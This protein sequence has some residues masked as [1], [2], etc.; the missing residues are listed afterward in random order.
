MGQNMRCFRCEATVSD[1]IHSV[2][3]K[4]SIHPSLHREPRILLVCSPQPNPGEWRGEDTCSVTGPNLKPIRVTACRSQGGDTNPS[5]RAK[6]SKE[7]NFRQTFPGF[8]SN[9]GM[10][11]TSSKDFQQR[12]FASLHRG[13][14][15]LTPFFSDYVLIIEYWGKTKN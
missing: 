3:G 11:N 4:K 2:Q 9:Y 7:V 5:Q 8:T 15:S 6:D 14:L 13:A 12:H 10:Q 1:T